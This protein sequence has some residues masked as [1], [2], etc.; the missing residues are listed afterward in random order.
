MREASER[1]GTSSD[2]PLCTSCLNP[3]DPLQHYCVTCGQA[4]GPYTACIPFVN[5]RLQY[6]FL[7]RVWHEAW[8]GRSV[9]PLRR[10]GYLLFLV[11]VSPEMLVGLPFV[12]WRRIKDR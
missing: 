10:G 2:V 4:V 7:G 5:I 12:L 8:W 6:D 3:V 9:P 11:L 1:D